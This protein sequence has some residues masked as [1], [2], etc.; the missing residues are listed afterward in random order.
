MLWNSEQWETQ[1]EFLSTQRNRTQKEET[2][3]LLR[4][5]RADVFKHTVILVQQGH[6]YNEEQQKINF[7]DANIKARIHRQSERNQKA[8][9]PQRVASHDKSRQRLCKI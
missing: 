7:P 2:K 6:Y 5:M 4:K 3:Y 8:L 9:K 1:F